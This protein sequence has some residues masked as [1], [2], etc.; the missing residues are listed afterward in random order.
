[1]QRGGGGQYFDSHDETFD[2][3]TTHRFGRIKNGA[4]HIWNSSTCHPPPAPPRK[5]MKKEGYMGTE[6]FEYT[7]LFRGDFARSDRP[8]E[9]DDA[10]VC[11]FRSCG[12][13]WRSK[14]K[15]GS[16]TLR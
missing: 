11:V 8:E 9:D 4:P 7:R 2:R 16:A 1:M 5:R 10:R 3:T 12:H 15:Y 13:G 6:E 14:M